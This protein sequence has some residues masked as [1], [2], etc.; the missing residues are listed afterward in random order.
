MPD[1]MAH[2]T[3]H[4]R[5]SAT[6]LGKR[7]SD[8]L[9]RRHTHTSPTSTN[10]ETAN[11][12][13][14]DTVDTQG[15][16]NDSA[17]PSVPLGSGEAEKR[18]SPRS[19]SWYSRPNF[20]SSPSL[21]QKEVYDRADAGAGPGLKIDG[22]HG[23]VPIH[24]TKVRS[25]PAVWSRDG[26]RATYP[27]TPTDVRT[28][29]LQS[30]CA[31]GSGSGG[32]SRKGAKHLEPIGSE[33]LLKKESSVT[34]NQSHGPRPLSE[35][36]G[37]CAGNWD[38]ETE[39]EARTVEYVCSSCHDFVSLDTIHEHFCSEQVCF[40]PSHTHTPTRTHTSNNTNTNAHASGAKSTPILNH[41]HTSAGVVREVTSEV[42]AHS[43]R[44]LTQWY[45][46][47]VERV[48]L[49]TTP[50]SRKNSFYV[51]ADG[52]ENTSTLTALCMRP[53]TFSAQALPCVS[54]GP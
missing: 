38:D 7:I 1:N 39:E 37:D 35:V 27:K 15:R 19:R 16:I 2:S 36:L 40:Y 46:E 20:W 3:A 24:S 34:S 47:V 6:K 41:M 52:E 17:Q 13:K 12:Q 18:H 32:S 54:S 4:W 43:T 22:P 31:R 21:K 23:E 29:S 51:P 53:P 25:L 11:L 30:L 42:R 10:I 8:F 9:T 14:E 26:R 49:S 28:R 5:V 33:G 45:W 48:Q 44:E 50:P